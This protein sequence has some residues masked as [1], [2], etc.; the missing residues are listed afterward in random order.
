MVNGGR[1]ATL[2]F[3][4]DPTAPVGG[5]QEFLSAVFGLK[6]P[7]PASNPSSGGRLIDLGERHKLDYLVFTTNSMAIVR[8]PGIYCERGRRMV[9]QK[10]PRAGLSD[11]QRPRPD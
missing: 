2:T 5:N 4:S 7:T 11:P 1:G 6:S 10:N 3:A 9:A 8:I